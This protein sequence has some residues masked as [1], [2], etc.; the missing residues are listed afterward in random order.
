MQPEPNSTFCSL[1]LVDAYL[2]SVAEELNGKVN[3][4]FGG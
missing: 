4:N 2:A 3:I 1:V